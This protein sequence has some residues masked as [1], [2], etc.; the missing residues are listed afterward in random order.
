MHGDYSRKFWIAAGVLLSTPVIVFLIFDT[1]FFVSHKAHR[2]LMP[3][4][5]DM[6]RPES[7]GT[8]QETSVF[9]VKRTGRFL[10]PEDVSDDKGAAIIALIPDGH[11]EIK[12]EET[13]TKEER[14]KSSLFVHQR[15]RESFE[16]HSNIGGLTVIHSFSETGRE[17][18]TIH[19]AFFKAAPHVSAE[20]RITQSLLEVSSNR[21]FYIHGHDYYFDLKL[22][23]ALMADLQYFFEAGTQRVIQSPGEKVVKR[24]ELKGSSNFDSMVFFTL[25]NN[26]SYPLTDGYLYGIL[27]SKPYHKA[28]L[29]VSK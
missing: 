17:G 5:A 4:V 22:C 11:H 24:I 26:L 20:E 25:D 18:A 2:N 6:S 9:A 3:E 1:L 15:T 14:V 28:T 12:P 16:A 13:Q 8:E 21:N 10:D 27:K 19:R 29:A 23:A 7:G